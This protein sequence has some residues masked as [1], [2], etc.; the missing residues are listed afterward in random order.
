MDKA[1][2]NAIERAT[3]QARKL[4]DEDFSSQLEGTFD[5]LRNGVI[6]ATGGTHL[7]AFQQSQRRKI[8]AA[9]EH[10]RASGMNVVDAVTDYVRDAAF[11]TLNRFVALKML[12][13]RELVQECIT[14]GEQSVGYR[15]FC[16]MAPGIALLPD[17]AGYRL[18]IECLFDEFSTEIKVL[19]DRR[20][21]ASVLWPRRQTFDTLLAILNTQD[22]S[23]V[24]GDDETIGWVYQF[25]NSGEER[26]EMRDKSQAPRNSRELAVRNQF[27]TPR[28]VVQFLVD[29]TLGRL[30][31]EMH[32]AESHLH[33]KCEYLVRAGDEA[34]RDRKRKDPRD[35]RIL[36]PACGSGHFLLYS[37]DLLLTIYEEAWSLREGAPRCETTGRTLRGD[38][39]DLASLRR[40]APKLIIEQN[41]HGVDID[42]R[43]AQIAALALWLRAQRAWKESA[44]PVSERNVHRTHIV[45]AEPM[46]GD[47]TLVNEFAARLDPPLLRDL[48]RKMVAETR[49]A[50]ELGALLRIEDGIAA[51]LRSAREQF[52]RHQQATGFL[53]GMEVLPLQE[54][55]DF[56]GIDDRNFFHEAEVQILKSLHAFAETAAGSLGVRRRLFAGDSAQGVAL[57]DVLRTRFE[58]ILMNPPFGLPTPA[59]K[60]ALSKLYPDSWTDLFNAF[61]DRARSLSSKDG[62]LVGAIIPDRLLVTKKSSGIRKRLLEQVGISTLVDIGPDVMDRAAVSAVMLTTDSGA[63]GQG[64]AT[65]TLT[66]NV[67]NRASELLSWAKAPT[68]RSDFSK[69]SDVPGTPFVLDQT[70]TGIE[71]WTRPA[72]LEPDLAT[73]ATGAKTFDD[74]RFLR[75]WWEVAPHELGAKWI[76]VDVGGDYKP[77]L[78]LPKM[79]EHWGSNGREI[80]AKSQAERGTEAQVIQSSKYWFRF[81]IA[82]PYTSSIGFSPRLIFRDTIISTDAVAVIPKN[83]EDTMWLLGVLLSSWTEL[84]LTTF[85]TGRKTENSSVKSLPIARPQEPFALGRSTAQLIDIALD[86]ESVDETSRAFAGPFSRL[87]TTHI[88]SFQ[89]TVN[90]IESLSCSAYGKSAPPA[91]TPILLERAKHWLRIKDLSVPVAMS[92]LM[93]ILFGRWQNRCERDSEVTRDYKEGFPLLPVPHGTAQSGQHVDI[94]V[95]DIG[96]ESD[97]VGLLNPIVEELKRLSQM[98][99]GDVAW[100]DNGDGEVIRKYFR[101]EFFSEHVKRYSPGGRAAPIFWQLATP[102]GSYSVWLYMH[103]LTKDTFFR[104][105][106]DFIEPKL[107]L[108]QRRLADLSA[109]SG[110]SPSAT[111]REAIEDHRT[112]VLELQALREEVKRISPLW[113]PTPDDGV[114][115]TMAPLWRLV[116]HHK[117]WQKELKSKWDELGTGKY[118]WAHIAMHLWP[119]RVIPKCATDRSLAI[120][121]DLEDVFWVLGDYGKWEARP[122]P[123]RPIEELVHERTSTAVKAALKSLLEAPTANSNGGRRRGGRSATRVANGGIS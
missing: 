108:E 61:L 6:T 98:C 21:T 57:I 51:E 38:Y 90:E 26:K 68:Q 40:A 24:W 22:L 5:V 81:A 107:L 31:L 106:T 1:I 33:T 73:V 121:H 44:T 103:T 23:E 17:A 69:F 50:G 93:G 56:S 27:F 87:S 60:T 122:F 115:L 9:I 28:Y 59:T 113:M 91:I 104:L 94:A 30:W 32:G 4:L 101:C 70:A 109:D 65:L 71:L 88:S 36:D 112:L 63:L 118:D 116:P 8:L 72:R 119:E 29:N 41:L 75:A 86:A 46:P 76:P 58:V 35:L 2:R 111:A 47:S 42:P 37:F 99:D 80:K 83:S 96:H 52:I 66:R 12:E 62:A 10:K 84:A 34:Y 114:V 13:A 39:P 74:F 100:F 79:V 82:Y 123:T 117:S 92:H 43:C 53:P 3:Q 54:S 11:T 19:F 77:A 78:S 45:L 97:L 85:G 7:S 49:L 120:A 110:P 48:F 55:L 15:E 14:K 64:V 102:S 105:Q 16:G 95:D 67:D 89:R 25:F 20:D 18:Y